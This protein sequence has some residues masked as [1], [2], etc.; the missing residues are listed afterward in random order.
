MFENPRRGRQARNLTSNV[1]KILDSEQIFS[2]IDVGCP[3]NMLFMDPVWNSFPFCMRTVQSQTGTKV[4]HGGSA[5]GTKSSR[6]EFIFRQVPCKRM[7]R[8][9]SMDIDT[10]SYRSELVPVRCYNPLTHAHSPG[11]HLGIFWV[12]MCRLEP[13]IG[14]QFWKRFP[15]KLIPR[16]RNGWN[17]YPPL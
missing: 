7:K 6:S 14:T 4:T 11:G 3:W 2:E 12:G 15:L 9:V 16:S 13:Q 1:P 17:F 10:N 5:T 8:N